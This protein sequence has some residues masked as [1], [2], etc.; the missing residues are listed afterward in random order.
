LEFIRYDEVMGLLKGHGVKEAPAE[1]D[2]VYLQMEDGRDVVHLHLAC[3]ESTAPPRDGASVVPVEKDRLPTVVDHVI[4]KLHLNQVLLIPVCKWRKV[5]DAVAF[6]LADNEEWQA[7]D[8]AATVELNT[9]DPLLCEPGDF[10]TLSAMMKVLI[11][12]ADSPDQGLTLTTTATPV[13]VEIVPDGAVRIS[14]GNQVLADEV[15]EAFGS[16]EE[17]RLHI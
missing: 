16:G 17:G 5:F 12:D 7:M 2:R 11:N 1:E 14:I 8:A 9:R 6:S 13:T 10:H 4:H 3:H 15:V